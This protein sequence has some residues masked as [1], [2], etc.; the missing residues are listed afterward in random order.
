MTGNVS[1]LQRTHKHTVVTTHAVG[2]RAGVPYELERT[3]CAECGRVLGERPLRRA[4][5]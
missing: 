2:Q 4:A 1:T 5:A 3:V